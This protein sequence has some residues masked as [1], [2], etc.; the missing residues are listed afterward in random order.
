MIEAAS[1]SSCGNFYGRA[2][3]V[4][5]LSHSFNS[6]YPPI[7]ISFIHIWG[8]VLT[9]GSLF[10]S[11]S[12][13]SGSFILWEVYSHPCLSNSCIAILQYPH[14]SCVYMTMF[15]LSLFWW[16]HVTACGAF[17]VFFCCPTV[18]TGHFVS[19]L[20]T[21]FVDSLTISYL[22]AVSLQVRWIPAFMYSIP[23]SELRI[24][25]FACAQYPCGLSVSLGCSRN[26]LRNSFISSSFC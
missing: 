3:S 21:I 9:F 17:I 11:D 25:N 14:P 12:L 1:Y 20:P 23:L 5:F 24:L 4:L 13:N 15:M 7:C 8:T 19:C 26:I 18:Y 22:E 16:F 2:F 10:I 6:L